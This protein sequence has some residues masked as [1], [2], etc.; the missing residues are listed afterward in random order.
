MWP[1]RCYCTCTCVPLS[2][3]WVYLDSSPRRMTLWPRPLWACHSVTV[4]WGRPKCP[5]L[6]APIFGFLVSYRIRLL[7]VGPMPCAVTQWALVTKTVA[8]RL[9][10]H[11]VKTSQTKVLDLSSRSRL[12][13]AYFDPCRGPCHAIRSRPSQGFRGTRSS[14][15]SSLAPVLSDAWDQF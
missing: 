8:C 2:S 15:R 10:C 9:W 6:S 5:L 13:K 11:K 7:N 3:K 4:S 14:T 1:A 12:M